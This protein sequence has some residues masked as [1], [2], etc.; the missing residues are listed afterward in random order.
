MLF[1]ASSGCEIG[2]Q[3]RLSQWNAFTRMPEPPPDA[4]LPLLAGMTR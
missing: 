3:K 1:V 4:S 2:G